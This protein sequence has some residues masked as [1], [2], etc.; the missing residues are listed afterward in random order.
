MKSLFDFHETLEMVTNGILEIA[1]NATDA[2]KVSNNEAK[3]KDYK[4]TYCIQSAV[5]SENFDKISHAESAKET[6]DILVKYYERGEKVK[7]VKLQTLRRK[8]E[9]LK[10][11]E[12]EKI[13][14][15]VS[16]V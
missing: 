14:G 1:E 11:G 5:D 7:V 4:V 12:D 3:K 6:L 16:K 2:Q 9:S 15:Y 13:V 10:M 8:Y